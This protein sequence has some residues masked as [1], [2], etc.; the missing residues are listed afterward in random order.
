MSSGDP[1][2][3]VNSNSKVNYS[4]EEIVQY[5]SL[6]PGAYPPGYT[7]PG[8]AE[9]PVQTTPP[10]D[11]LPPVKLSQQQTKPIVISP[12][13][14]RK[15]DQIRA[16]EGDQ[17]LEDVTPLR[18]V[19]PT[20]Q[21]KPS[22]VL[23]SKG[24][25][26]FNEDQ[27]LTI[28]KLQ[29][30]K[31][32]GIT[33]LEIFNTKGE[34][35]G[36]TN[37][38]DITRARYDILSE[39]IKLGEP[40]TVKGSYTT[41][42]NS[43]ESTQTTYVRN[44]D[45]E[46][47]ALIAGAAEPGAYIGLAF[48]GGVADLLG[49]PVLGVKP[50]ATSEDINTQIEKSIGPTYLDQALSG[51]VNDENTTPTEKAASLIGT[52]AG[53]V[54]TSGGKIGLG[55]IKTGIEEKLTQLGIVKG[56]KALQEGELV[57]NLEKPSK[58]NTNYEFSQGT[59]AKSGIKEITFDKAPVQVRRTPEGKVEAV[60]PEF[61]SDIKTTKT[62]ETI[63]KVGEKPVP[64]NPTDEEILNRYPLFGKGSNDLNDLT[65]GEVF[66]AQPETTVKPE[67]GKVEKTVPNKLE[68]NPE[69]EG[70]ATI[71][72]AIINPKGSTLLIRSE[73][74]TELPVDA[75]VAK[76][77]T[78]GEAIHL[79]LEEVKG[80]KGVYYGKLTK[81][82][83]E[84][85]TEGILGKTLKTGTDL[86]QYATKDFFKDSDFLAS[87]ARNPEIYG[88][89][90]DTKIRPFVIRYIEGRGTYNLKTPK[91]EINLKPGKAQRSFSEGQFA[92]GNI[93]I[94]PTAP[95]AAARAANLLKDTSE[96]L[97]KDLRPGKV[98]ANTKEAESPGE[99]NLNLR[100]DNQRR[101]HSV[102]DT[103]DLVYEKIAYPP[104]HR[105]TSMEKIQTGLED[106]TAIKG[107][108]DLK[109]DTGLDVSS[110]ARAATSLK[111]KTD[112]GSKLSSRLK[113]DVDTDLALGQ[114][115]GLITG[116]GTTQKTTTTTKQITTTDQ[117]QLTGNPPPKRPMITG[118][119]FDFELPPEF[120]KTM[121]KHGTGKI[122]I[123]YFAWNVNSLV[124]GGYLP[125][126]EL[127]V[128]KSP[129]AITQTVKLENKVN[130][131][132]GSK[133]YFNPRKPQG[134]KKRSGN[135]KSKE[136]AQ[137]FK[138]LDRSIAGKNLLSK[139]RKWF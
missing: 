132:A 50:G 64:T 11:E 95:G 129:K 114:M 49:K 27:A 17:P 56:S 71:P 94:G 90:F 136:A 42:N 34:K 73:P 46:V 122:K 88:N 103:S 20:P 101:Y 106:I 80:Q 79:G 26:Q 128:S 117:I 8:V 137:T 105:P 58:T 109:I 36:E 111:T 24:T 76:N 125:G 60:S 51:N 1:P 82:L 91:K 67:F 54:F 81:H 118:G 16:S 5:Q 21:Q 87:A 53:F 32:A 69:T 93:E 102:M 115:H 61:P 28:S 3:S 131:N 2:P 59:I 15:S 89:V 92:L 30:A 100:S 14:L 55:A 4:D 139:K 97:P 84:K 133:V 48:A 41:S 74:Q 86:F 85:I 107:K 7:P 99:I 134:P 96:M 29:E 13:N 65:K 35:V 130:R 135:K 121:K 138:K 124:P 127:R 6:H 12:G 57:S 68:L 75:I 112:Q 25:Q 104:G 126:K 108:V 72:E 62:I 39:S 18:V 110:K 119:A 123:I 10:P 47:K 38:Q 52:A 44:N 9:K 120:K 19:Q 45:N 83:Q 40:V 98:S 116:Q 63:G 22:G 77:I 43:S 33:K 37:P 78:P 70:Q 23:V 31:S 113:L 66:K